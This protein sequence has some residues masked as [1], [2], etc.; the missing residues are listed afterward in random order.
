MNPGCCGNGCPPAG[1]G[2]ITGGSSSSSSSYGD[3]CG[4]RYTGVDS[5]L[6]CPWPV[7]RRAGAGVRFRLRMGSYGPYWPGA[8]RGWSRS[9]ASGVRLSVRSSSEDGES[10]CLGFT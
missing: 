6:R 4:F 7:R 1:C 3:E 10:Y 9:R 2:G 8:S 5:V